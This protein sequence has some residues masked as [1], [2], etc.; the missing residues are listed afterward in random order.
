MFY[1]GLHGEVVEYLLKENADP[2]C[3][4]KA[5]KKAFQMTR[6]EKFCQFLST[7]EAE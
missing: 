5:G 7:L 3:L 1:K 2:D 4:N 6:D